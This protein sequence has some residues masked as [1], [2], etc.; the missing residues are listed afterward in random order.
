MSGGCLVPCL[1]SLPGYSAGKVEV[2]GTIM[3]IALHNSDP[4]QAYLAARYNGEIYGTKDGGSTWSNYSLPDQV[5]DIYTL[6]CS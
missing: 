6:A 4:N 2:H 3:S 5:K 1:W